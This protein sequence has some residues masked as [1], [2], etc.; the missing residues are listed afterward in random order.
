MGTT[1]VL[2]FM[3]SSG[4]GAGRRCLPEASLNSDSEH[5]KFPIQLRLNL[6]RQLSLK[7]VDDVSFEI[8]IIM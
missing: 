7:F 1:I 5:L 2:L 8:E 3:V 4:A 6:R